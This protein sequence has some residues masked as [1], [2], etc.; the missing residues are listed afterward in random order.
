M[1]K[2]FRNIFI[3]MI[4]VGTVLLAASCAKEKTPIN[5]YLYTDNTNLNEMTGYLCDESIAVKVDRP[6]IMDRS[7]VKDSNGIGYFS[8]KKDYKSKEVFSLSNGDDSY[9]QVI[10]KEDVPIDLMISDFFS[11]IIGARGQ[12]TVRNIGYN[13]IVEKPMAFC[14]AC[15]KPT[16]DV[17]VY[18]DSQSKV[19][20]EDLA[21]IYNIY[22]EDSKYTF[23]ETEDFDFSLLDNESIY[24]RYGKKEEIKG[25]SVREYADKESLYFVVNSENGVVLDEAKIKKILTGKVRYWEDL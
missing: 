4:M 21:K 11:F 23:I 1:R 20:A 5:I 6:D 13:A 19:L 24:F 10:K 16:G 22:S 15:Y 17:K 2:H 14:G 25:L 8:D 9:F 7:V 18:Y 12:E 3:L